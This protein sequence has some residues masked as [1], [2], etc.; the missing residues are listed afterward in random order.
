[1]KYDPG[2]HHRRSIRFRGYD[3]SQPG[4]YFVTLCTHEKKHLF[5]EIVEGEMKLNESGE[6]LRVFWN[7]LPRRYSDV[8]LDSFVVM[9]N[10]IHGIVVVGAIRESP[11]QKTDDP[12]DVG[13]IHEL[14]RDE[15]EQEGRFV[16]RPYQKRAIHE[17]PLRR[18]MLLP[19]AIGYFKMKTARRINELCGTRG[20]PVWQRNYYEHIVRNEDELGKIREYIATN[21][22]RWLA[23]PENA[24]REGD[25]PDM[26]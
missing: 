7:H 22:L 21:P 13:A 23:D 15:R 12:R 26:L 17:S 5:G 2:I 19:K 16:N 8:Q 24:E 9:P 11:L 10:H 14:P 18:R 4:A 3:Y 1:M 25:L 6:M 20:A